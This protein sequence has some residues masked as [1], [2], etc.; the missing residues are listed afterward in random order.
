MVGIGH[1]GILRWVHAVNIGRYARRYACVCT[2]VCTED[3]SYKLIVTSHNQCFTLAA[4][5]ILNAYPPCI[6]KLVSALIS[7]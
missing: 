1:T 3:D 6:L 7:E 2:E 4:L 5:I